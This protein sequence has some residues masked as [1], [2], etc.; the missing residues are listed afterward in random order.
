MREAA[1]LLS[2]ASE[3]EAECEKYRESQVGVDSMGGNTLR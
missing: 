2:G 1:A 3:E